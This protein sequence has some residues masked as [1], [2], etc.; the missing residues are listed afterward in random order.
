MLSS[1]ER[2][3]SMY[4]THVSISLKA[5]VLVFRLGNVMAPPL[6]WATS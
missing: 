2:R 5:Y 4:K 3:M 1:V 6:E